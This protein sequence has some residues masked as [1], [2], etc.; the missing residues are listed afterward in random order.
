MPSTDQL[1]HYWTLSRLVKS[2]DAK[3]VF[4]DE[5][6][7][8]FN[9]DV[10]QGED[11]ENCK[12]S[13]CEAKGFD[14]EETQDFQDNS[15]I[16]FPKDFKVFAFDY[17]ITDGIAYEDVQGL[18]SVDEITSLISLEKLNEKLEDEGV[19]ISE[20]EDDVMLILERRVKKAGLLATEDILFDATKKLL[21]D[22][23][24]WMDDHHPDN[25]K[26]A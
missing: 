14:T 9:L 23:R 19:L 12:Y 5:N 6:E 7:E 22:L 1:L 18:T 21:N 25:V 17:C 8:A 24:D 15:W 4:F 13:F 2:E 20:A 3:V 11:L 10:G 26:T 16:S